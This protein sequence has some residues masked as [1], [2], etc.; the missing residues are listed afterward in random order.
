MGARANAIRAPSGET[1][2]AP[3]YVREN[4]AVRRMLTV[5]KTRA[6]RHQP[7]VREYTISREGIV[8]DPTDAPDSAA[9]RGPPNDK[10][11]L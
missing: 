2:S 11:L 9:Y 4:S 10:R 5:L 8:L 6:S 1:A 7:E 3:S